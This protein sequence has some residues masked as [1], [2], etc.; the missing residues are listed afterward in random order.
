M[1]YIISPEMVIKCKLYHSKCKL[2]INFYTWVSPRVRG[3]KVHTPTLTLAIH[4]RGVGHFWVFLF[5]MDLEAKGIKQHTNCVI[6]E[7]DMNSYESMCAKVN[8]LDFE[9]LKKRENGQLEMDIGL[10]FHP[11]GT[12]GEPLVCLWVLEKTGQ[13]Y[14]AAGMQQ[15]GSSLY[16]H[17]GKLWRSAG[18]DISD[19]KFTCADLFLICL[20]IAL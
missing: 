16:K 14:R 17:N 15:G 5:V 7:D 3:L 8:Y 6:S 2:H 19:Q 10:G 9:Y 4:Y 13:S 11:I 12:N 1:H 20:W 18:G